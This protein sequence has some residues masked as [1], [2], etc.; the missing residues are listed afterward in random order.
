MKKICTLIFA[1]VSA[2]LTQQLN[3]VVSTA[4]PAQLVDINRQAAHRAIASS[5]APRQNTYAQPINMR[6]PMI[7]TRPQESSPQPNLMLPTW[8]AGSN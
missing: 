4:T 5:V 8:I 3:G 7:N 6:N 2:F 1:L